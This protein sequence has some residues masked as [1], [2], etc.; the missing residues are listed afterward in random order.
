MANITLTVIVDGLDNDELNM[1]GDRVNTILT[2][3]T[4]DGKLTGKIE[5]VEELDREED[6]D[7][8]TE[9]ED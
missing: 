5:S 4:Q 9:T 3:A 2:T 7:E 8:E 6:D 1:I